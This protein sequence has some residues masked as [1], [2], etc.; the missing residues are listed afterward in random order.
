[1]TLLA[2]ILTAL[3]LALTT[4]GHAH[5]ELQPRHCRS[6]TGALGALSAEADH[7]IRFH[8]EPGR[9]P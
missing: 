2:K 9:R 6:G 3:I 4:G 7:F 1:M 8:P 5:R